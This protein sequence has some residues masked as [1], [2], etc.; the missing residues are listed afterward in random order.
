MRKRDT[1]ATAFLL[2]CAVLFVGGTAAKLNGSSVAV[3]N[4]VLL[5][6]HLSDGV[7]LSQAREARSDEWEVWTPAAVAQSRL[8]PPFPAENPSL[9]YG[10]TPLIYNLPVRHYTLLFRPQFWGFFGLGV[11][12]GYA[13]Y[14]NAKLFGLLASLATSRVPK[15][16]D[17]SDSCLLIPGVVM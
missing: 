16:S 13:W 3:W 5:E 9:G 10:K 7:L 6:N 8:D 4:R 12:R 1:I 17:A 11:E 2:L 14:W 15:C